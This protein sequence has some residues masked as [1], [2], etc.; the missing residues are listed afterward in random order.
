M[1]RNVFPAHWLVAVFLAIAA[2]FTAWAQFSTG[3][4][5][6]VADPTGAVIPKAAVTAH[7]E[8]TNEDI[9]TVSSSSGD[10]SFTSLKPGIYDIS[11]TAPGFDTAS[12]TGVH[13]QLEATITVKLTLKPGTAKESVTVR[14]D[15]VQL[16][17]T[18]ADRGVTYSTDELEQSPFDSGNPLMLANAEPGVYFNGCSSC[19]WVRPFDN[20]S[21]N[22]FS[23]NGQGSDTNDFQLDGS[24]NNANTYGS[25]NIGYVPPTASIQEMKFVSNPY[26]AQYGHTGGGIFDVVTK[27]GTNQ[28]HG[29]L[30]ENARRT[31]LDA[32]THYNDNPTIDLPKTSDQRDQYGFEVDGPV[33]IP[34]LYNGRDKTFFEGQFEN[35]SQNTPNSGIDNVPALSPGSTSQSVVQTGDFSQAYYFTGSA[36]EQ[37]NIFDP[38]TATGSSGVR[39][40]FSG[41]QVPSTRLNSTAQALLSYLPLPNVA[42]PS[43]QSWGL[44]NY[45]WQLTGTDRF[46]NVVAR[47][48]QNFGAHDKAYLRFAWNKRFQ[49]NGDANGLPGAAETG[50]FPLIRQNHFFTADWLHTFNSNSILDMHL[51][52]TRYIDAEKE[53]LT[54]FDLSKVGLG[55]LAIPGTVSVFPQIGVSG[56]TGFGNWASNGGNK[57][58][59]SNTIAAMPIW[60]YIRSKHTIKVGLDYRWM[61]ASNFTAGASSGS[62]SVGTGWTQ[63]QAFN[64]P[65][66]LAQTQGLGLASMLLG[67]MDSGYI[68]I[69]ANSYFSYPYFAPFF[70]DDWKV[71]QKLTVNLGARWDLQGPPSEANNKML[72]DLNTTTLNPVSSEVTAALPNGAALVGGLTFAGVNGQPR[73]LFN[74]DAAAIQPRVGFA[75]ALNNKTV[76]RGGIGDTFIQFA[77][78]GYNNGFSQSTNYV[79]STDG[80][81]LPNGADLSNPIP[82]I[83]QPL[84][85][86]LGLESQLGNS[87]N[88]SNRNFKIPGVV[89]YSLGAERQ[90]N[91]HTTVDLSF[92][93]STGFQQDTTDDINHIS[94]GYAANCNL[95][96]GASITTYNNCN[97]EPQNTTQAAANPE[98]VTNPF[99]GVAGFSTAN[100]G[101]GNGYYTNPYL[102]ASDFTRPMPQFGEIYQSQQND[103]QTQF[104]SLQA[105]VTHRWSDALTAHGSFVWAKTMDSGSIID[106]TYRVRAHYV[107]Y[108][109]RKWRWTANAVWH[110]PVGRGRAFLGNSNRIVDGVVGGWTMGAIYY[111]QAGTRSSVAGTGCSESYCNWV[112]LIHKQNYGVHRIIRTGTPFI[113]AS[114]TCVGYYDSNGNLQPE[115]YAVC[116]KANPTAREDFDFIQRPSW[117]VYQNVSDSG[118]YNPRGQQL[119][120]SMSKTF[121]VWER[122]KLE[123]RF[124]AYNLPN[125]PNWDGAGYWWAPFDPHFGTI[126]MIYSGQTDVPRNVQLSAKFMW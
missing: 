118:V 42:T 19:E 51:S 44:Q 58:S 105:V 117:G 125:H 104:N 70:Q 24:P 52:F 61:H 55:S 80:G 108:G 69:N 23:A 101:N 30:Y 60:T 29:Q 8:L 37:I 46:K 12:E 107:D 43:N 31:W 95:E 81:Y 113:A 32:N 111:Y 13:V 17:L 45:K 47:L 114:S 78:Q 74:Q 48:D 4:T 85:A 75:Y 87:F 91:A 41:N 2:P 6:R 82:A 16:D 76:V 7:N 53:G 27:Y 122:T 33:V 94:T 119:D 97:S 66:Q 3:V 56:V 57:V 40:Q 50:V 49:N 35:Y 28:L 100:T 90:L 116:P 126:N 112:E 38:L 63:G 124:E 68:S 64:E 109:N 18:H 77:G 67:T 123:M 1:I 93:G 102:P 121:P 103:G 72:G 106:T 86:A 83:A 36:D 21:I 79:G 71:T 25:R 96:M 115:G 92:V 26:D 14:A 73:T 88:V 39:T 84:G 62:F 10:F 34:F 99:V 54:P 120:M 15:E 65:N 20:N 5:G 22:Q 59:I 98:W 11:A 89:N 110:M 9:N